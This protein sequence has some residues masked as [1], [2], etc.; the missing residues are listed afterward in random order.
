MYRN[1]IEPIKF[2]LLTGEISYDEAKEMMEP[3]IQEM[4]EKGRIIAKQHNQK[5]KPFTFSQLMR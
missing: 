4:N 1:K 2:M 5:F 3:I